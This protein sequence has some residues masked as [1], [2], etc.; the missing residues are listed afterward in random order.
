MYSN[1]KTLAWAITSGNLFLKRKITKQLSA[2]N[3]FLP[4]FQGRLKFFSSDLGSTILKFC[5]KCLHFKP[6]VAIF[7]GGGGSIEYTFLLNTIKSM[8]TKIIYDCVDELSGFSGADVP[9]ISKE[10]RE[11]ASNSSIIITT[12]EVLRQRLSKL[13]SNCFCIPNAVDF[14]HFTETAKTGQRIAEVERL[15]NPIIGY[16]GAISEWFDVE[17][18]CKLAD[19]HPEY[20]ILLVGPLKYGLEKF[21]QHSNITLL[22]A[23]KYQIIPKYLSYMDVCLIPFKI[24]KLTSAV[25]PIKLYEYLALGKPVVS[26]NLPD[27]RANVSELVYIGKNDQDFIRK[28]EDAVG[29][30]KKPESQSIIKRRIEF[31]QNNSWEKRVDTIEKLLKGL[32]SSR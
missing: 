17:L 24:N 14:T 22:G 10:E 25:N 4:P 19:L 15:R 26:T 3:V 18:V 27:V 20:S 5:V 31:A 30:R 11:I 23:K 7:Y 2:V 1:F 13:N 32:P 9:M 28:V 12:S 8:G 6:E 29:E 16:I 21:K